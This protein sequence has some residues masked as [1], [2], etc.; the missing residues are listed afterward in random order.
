MEWGW[1]AIAVMVVAWEMPDI[2]RAWRCKGN[3]E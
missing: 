3:N 1:I 2:I